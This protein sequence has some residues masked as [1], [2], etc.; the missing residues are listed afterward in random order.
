MKSCL[1]STNNFP[2]ITNKL[3]RVKTKHF[4]NANLG[5]ILFHWKTYDRNIQ[6]VFDIRQN[7]IHVNVIDFASAHSNGMATKNTAV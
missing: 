7:I 3:L 6:H 1:K 4:R 5:H 2:E